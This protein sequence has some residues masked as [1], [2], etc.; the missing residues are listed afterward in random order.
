MAYANRAARRRA[1]WAALHNGNPTPTPAPSLSLSSAVVQAEGNSG[2][3]AFVW[4]LTLNRDGAT[5]AYPFAWAV[6]GSG[7]NPA[8][9]A[10]FGGAFPSG[11]GTF[12]AGET[13]KTITV[14]A[15]GDTAVEPNE[16]FTLTV[17]ASG[18]STV[19]STGTISNDDVATTPT[20]AARTA[21][22]TP[23]NPDLAAPLSDTFV[24]SAAGSL[25]TT[26]L[27]S[28]T[29]ANFAFGTNPGNMSK[30]ADG[31]G[32]GGN[33]AGRAISI[34][35]GYASGDGEIS[36]DLRVLV[37]ASEGMAGL[38]GRM[39]SADTTGTWYEF[40]YSFANTLEL[41]RVNGG[42]GTSLGT[43]TVSGSTASYFPAKM[44]IIDVG[45][46]TASIRCWFDGVEVISVI[47]AAPLPAG[48]FGLRGGRNARFRN[49]AIGTW[50]LQPALLFTPNIYDAAAADTTVSL[51]HASSPGA[52][53]S[54]AGNDGGRFTLVDTGRR[55][56]GRAQY[57]LKVGATQTVIADGAKRTV[58]FAETKANYPTKTTALDIGV[59]APLSAKPVRFVAANAGGHNSQVAG[60]QDAWHTYALLPMGSVSD[61][62]RPVFTAW[63]I[64]G[65]GKEYYPCTA[66]SVTKC[67]V[68]IEG[69]RFRV[70]VT[71]NGARGGTIPVSGGGKLEA[72]PVTPAM[73]GLVEWPRGVRLR[74]AAQGRVTGAVPCGEVASQNDTLNTFN[75]AYSSGSEID[76]VDNANIAPPNYSGK[77]N[78]SAALFLTAIVGAT[79]YNAVYALGDS[80]TYGF[81]ESFNQI[82]YGAGWFGRMSLIGGIIPGYRAA[83]AGV[84]GQ[85]YLTGNAGRRGMMAYASIGIDFFG[86]NDLNSAGTG[87]VTDINAM[88]TTVAS[89]FKSA[90]AKVLRGQL[91]ARAQDTAI[92]LSSIAV[93]GTDAVATITDSTSVATLQVGQTVT[94]AGN[95]PAALNGNKVITA[96][97]GNTFTYTV[98]SGTASATTVGSFSAS[99]SNQL[100][101]IPAGWAANGT[102]NRDQINAK[103]VADT[104]AGTIDGVID[105]VSAVSQPGNSGLWKYDGLTINLYTN[106]N[107]HPTATGHTAMAAKARDAILALAPE[108]A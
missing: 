20:Y 77:T 62:V 83:R 12:A 101:T 13:S 76:W 108:L 38:L 15:M 73:F 56:V 85:D 43:A 23:A 19:T 8:D 22:T 14:L 51:I 99:F 61:D 93:T 6:T 7:A 67:A 86:T 34:L 70:P 55:L 96:I 26:S 87:S 89:H 36:A 17:T 25:N 107:T 68:M 33:A 32:V 10:D 49:F 39:Q 88:H 9:V 35:N 105:F 60:G 94:L 97:N 71:F 66:A 52:T 30:F 48:V 59:V 16:T 69:G 64:G 1:A 91:L 103:N 21:N 100:Q 42:T 11:S 82:A 58:S 74:V 57:Y 98:T 95:T 75:S 90:G 47:D 45:D 84:L 5:A 18:L 65:D 4:T 63:T 53:L 81:S 2:T 31:S 40:R 41:F 54:L 72:D 27:G 79:S 46:G 28:G 106:D 102:S 37:T 3:T 80:I 78:A 29:W 92:P 104:Q 44:R 24:V 50:Q